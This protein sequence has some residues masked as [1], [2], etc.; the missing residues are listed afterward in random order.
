M[1]YFKK[2]ESVA[3]PFSYIDVF[4]ILLAVLAISFGIYDIAERNERNAD[5]LYHIELSTQISEDLQKSVPEAGD[6]LFEGDRAI[7][8]VLSVEFREGVDIFYVKAV[9]L[10]RIDHPKKGKQLILETANSV[11]EMKI[12]SAEKADATS[13]GRNF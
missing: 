3:L 11:C 12:D 9:C 7:G 13:E 4:F 6:I 2:K 8:E 5:P 10:M 1:K